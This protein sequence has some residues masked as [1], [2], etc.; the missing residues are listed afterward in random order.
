M[1]FVSGTIELIEAESLIFKEAEHC[2]KRGSSEKDDFRRFD[3]GDN[4]ARIN[5]LSKLLF[6]SRARA[7]ANGLRLSNRSI[8]FESDPVWERLRLSNYSKC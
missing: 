3:G 2:K 5:V 4:W 1:L 8:L 6:F 7:M